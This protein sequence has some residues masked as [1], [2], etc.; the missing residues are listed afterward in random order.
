M[1]YWWFR[2]LL[3][4]NAILL[5]GCAVVRYA[6]YARPAIRFDRPLNTPLPDAGH[7]AVREAVARW[8]GLAPAARVKYPTAYHVY[9]DTPAPGTFE[10]AHT[11]ALAFSGGGSRGILFGAACVVE[12]QALGPIV[13]DTA[14]GP[15]RI[16]LLDEVD[17]VSGVSTGSIPAALF[18]LDRGGTCPEALRVAHWPEALNRSVRNRGLGSLA[19]RPDWWVRDYFVDIN[20]HP[21]AAGALAAVYFDGNRFQ[22]GSGLRFGDLPR[23]PVLLLASSIVNDPGAPFV[24]TR[25]PY[26]HAL[27]EM[28]ELPWTVGVQSLESFR[29]DPL[30]YPLGEACH[31]SLS[32]P[33]SMRSGLLRVHPA[34]AWVTHG[35]DGAARA[36]MAR[37]QHQ[38]FY[39][40]VYMLKDGGLADNRGAY[41]VWRLFDAL[42]EQENLPPRPL[43]IGLNADR[44][45]L[46]L[47]EAGSR[48]MRESWMSELAGSLGTTYQFGQYAFDELMAD[49]AERQ[50]FDYLRLRYSAWA[51]YLPA[52]A[53]E[54]YGPVDASAG[55]ADYEEG[56]AQLAAL[57]AAEPG[58]RD[59][60]HLLEVGL[61]LG[62]HIHTLNTEEMAAVRVAARFAVWKNRAA[63]VA[64]ASMRHDGAP[65]RFERTQRARNTDGLRN[66][67]EAV[68]EESRPPPNP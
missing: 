62:T 57:C 65:A 17:Y 8:D 54:A 19:M 25:L 4:I 43:L 18:A 33:A 27:D 14:D 60:A 59:T 55:P 20:T 21:A 52:A 28:R 40:G 68:S 44:L 58:I 67:A 13:V 48:V 26:R 56:A 1:R 45:S 15:Q 41:V 53:F 29:S 30:A 12:L 63:L 47:P 61:R 2:F 11:I 49:A 46:R 37:A 38:P 9:V 23:T 22:P 16:A 42:L 24:F 7:P 10:G 64:W 6:D 34:R 50:P 5:P 39:E 31:N 66:P 35:L 3:V 32:F 36:R 51:A